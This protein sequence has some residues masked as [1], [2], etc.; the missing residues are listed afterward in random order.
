M[1]INGKGELLISRKEMCPTYGDYGPD[2]E[3]IEGFITDVPLGGQDHLIVFK[4][5]GRLW[6]FED[7]F[8]SKSGCGFDLDYN[9]DWVFRCVPVEAETV[10]S[11]KVTKGFSL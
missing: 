5:D 6:G 9:D 7:W 2:W 8:W 1:R 10:T 3:D 4:R 11:Y